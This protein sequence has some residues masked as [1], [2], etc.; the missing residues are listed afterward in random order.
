MALDEAAI[1]SLMDKVTS[2]ALALGVFESVNAHEPKAPPGSGMRY[3]VWADSIVPLGGASGLS[4]TSGEVVLMG[5]IYTSMLQRPEDGID[6]AVLTAATTLMG[7]YSGDFDFGA[8]VRNV[9]LLGAFGPRLSAQ[10]GYVTVSGSM[11]RVMTLTIP[12]IFNDMWSQ[13]A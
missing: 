1:L 13:V 7:A 4:A 10:A 9:D 3:A 8:T 6:P 5:R 12:V 11:F 2:H